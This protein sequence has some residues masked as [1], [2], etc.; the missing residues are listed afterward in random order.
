MPNV[1]KNEQRDKH[2]DY[3]DAMEDR[4]RRGII[5]MQLRSEKQGTSTRIISHNT[6]DD[7]ERGDKHK[8]CHGAM[9]DKDIGDRHEDYEIR[10]ILTM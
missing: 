3:H 9:D 10:G 4:E 6:M 7:R 8:D 1:L 2:K 5:T